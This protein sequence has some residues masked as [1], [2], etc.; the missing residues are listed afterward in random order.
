MN[1]TEYFIND[2]VEKQLRILVDDTVF[3]NENFRS[4]EMELTESLCSETPIRFGTCEASIFQICVLNNVMPLKG[5]TMEVSMVLKGDETVNFELGRY[6]VDSDK[7]TADR[8]YR[9]VTA[10]DAMYDVL[11]ADVTEWYN[12]VL[13]K[14]DST[15]TLKEFRDSFFTH[16]GMEQE[17]TVL[18]NDTMTVRR[19]VDATKLSGKTVINAI[20]EINGCFGHMGRS[21][22]FRYVVLKE[23]IEG[24]YPSDT[25]YPSENLYPASPAN[26][27]YVSKNSYISAEYEDYLMQKI[28]KLQI[29]NEEDEVGCIYGEGTNCYVVQDNFLL[30]G[31]PDEEMLEAA[32]NMYSVIRN[33][34]YR[35]AHV[36]AKGNPVLEAGDGIRLSTTYEIVYTY[37]FQRTL[38][39]IQALRDTYDAEGEEYQREKV[40]SVREE[41]V[42]LKGKTNKLTRT[43][44]ETKLELADL[45]ANAYAEIKANAEQISL[46]VSK[47]NLISEIN[48][49]AEA[50]TIKAEK[51]D[52]VGLVNAQELVAKYATVDTLEVETAK[53]KNLIAQK[54]TIEQLE[55]TN[56]K[57]EGKLEASEFTADKISAMSITVKGEN[58]TTGIDAGKITTGMISADRID[59]DT[60]VGKLVGQYVG[61]A[62]INC[63]DFVFRSSDV[64]WKE[65]T[66]VT[67]AG[68]ETIYYLG[69]G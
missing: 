54:A 12:R 37:I 62:R 47:D 48:Q 5:K 1:I 24:V 23:M 56:A 29:R 66:V 38:K 13:P 35:P 27:E 21:G 64:S 59:A 31:M 10:Y 32:A 15:L 11:N 36:E 58:V 14:A 41:I 68:T 60:I 45:E 52:L 61:V 8:K 17:E 63:G 33:I 7:P 28:D 4:E 20:C 49:T 30:Y 2:A 55:A 69:R 42:R 39:G 44:E 26:T 25:L 46:K 40:N 22:K 50:V 34:R 57:I 67:N 51:I 65:K 43:V 18:A 16:L 9:K 6:K 3:T 53:L 19:T